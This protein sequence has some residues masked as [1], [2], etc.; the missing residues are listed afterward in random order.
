MAASHAINWICPVKPP[1]EVSQT[2]YNIL[3]FGIIEILWYMIGLCNCVMKYDL[4]QVIDS[5]WLGIKSKNIYFKGVNFFCR[6]IKII[7]RRHSNTFLLRVMTLD[8]DIILFS[9]LG[10]LSKIHFRWFLYRLR[11]RVILTFKSTCFNGF[12][13]KK[14]KVFSS[15]LH[16]P[17]APSFL[18]PLLFSLL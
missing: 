17:K 5:I 3:C 16:S 15:D 8:K 11:S 7:C 1:L 14:S 9:R 18:L 4:K 13:P 6:V 10:R 12:G 2:L